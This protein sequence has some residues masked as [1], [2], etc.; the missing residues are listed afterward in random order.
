MNANFDEIDT[1]SK[2]NRLY[3]ASEERMKPFLLSHFDENTVNDYLNYRY[4]LR[5][6]PKPKAHS[7]K[8]TLLRNL[9]FGILGITIY[10]VVASYWDDYYEFHKLAGQSRKSDVFGFLIL[11][12]VAKYVPLI[13][14]V[15]ALL[16]VIYDYLQLRK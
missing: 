13:F 12:G 1:T 7:P 3:N 4:K 10:F 15:T 2:A 6:E 14:G 16:R 8:T 5:T 9:A 11:Y